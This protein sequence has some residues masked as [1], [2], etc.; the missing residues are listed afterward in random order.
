MEYRIEPT[1]KFISD[2][3]EL[4][5]LATEEFM[6]RKSRT[7]QDSSVRSYLAQ[8]IV[9]V[10][11]IEDSLDGSNITLPN[12]VIEK[13]AN[14]ELNEI[15]TG[16]LMDE[17]D[18]GPDILY[19]R[20][21]EEGKVRYGMELL[22]D[23]GTFSDVELNGFN[24]F[25]NYVESVGETMALKHQA[26]IIHDD[27]IGMRTHGEWRNTSYTRNLMVSGTNYDSKIID[28]E[29]AHFDDQPSYKDRSK[30]LGDMNPE[31]RDDEYQAVLNSLI[32]EGLR[33]L[34]I[35]EEEAGVKVSGKTAI[36][37]NLFSYDREKDLNYT[38]IEK[39]EQHVGNADFSNLIN[40]VRDRFETGIHQG[41][42]SVDQIYQNFAESRIPTSNQFTFYRN[43]L[44]S[45][46]INHYMKDNFIPGES[47]ASNSNKS[48]SM[49]KYR[50]N[51]IEKWVSETLQR[52]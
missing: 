4:D 5:F 33:T 18:V 43:T 28:W 29:D 38:D 42:L 51:E 32:I 50:K 6:E 16:L 45:E 34:D 30:Q 17:L 48:K 37:E 12:M 47:G 26:G 2:M 19:L 44:G 8:G 3:I 49:A 15:S 52:L 46:W 41:M 13:K 9:E 10:A 23:Y 40:H 7:I 24:D 1:E 22:F 27:L 35:F 25:L 21:D 11:E 36:K 14:R 39:L 20:R 31:T